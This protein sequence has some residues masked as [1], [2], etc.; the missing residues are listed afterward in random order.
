MGLVLH[1]VQFQNLSET[2]ILLIND[3][4]ED[5]T[6]NII[7]NFQKSDFRIKIINNHKNMG[8][9]Y[10]RSIGALISKGE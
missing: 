1:S 6:S 10:S 2:E 5:N 9:L 8:T 4:S 3:F 7:R